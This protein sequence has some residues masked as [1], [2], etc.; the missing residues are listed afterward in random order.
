VQ[1]SA[2]VVVPSAG[3]DGAAVMKCSID[4]A[5]ADTSRA[6][7]DALRYNA[8]DALDHGMSVV[9]ARSDGSK[10][11]DGIWKELQSRR[12]TRRRDQ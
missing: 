12:A 4:D 8:L 5:F 3:I 7:L 10:R 6:A 11:P 9:A 1:P 2:A